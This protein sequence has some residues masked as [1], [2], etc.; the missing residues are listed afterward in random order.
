MHPHRSAASFPPLTETKI[1][2][3]NLFLVVAEFFLC[4]LLF[5]SSRCGQRPGVRTFGQGNS[6]SFSPAQY[7]LI[8]EAQVDEHSLLTECTDDFVA[9][10]QLAKLID[11]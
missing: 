11:A 7:R 6:N 9:A 4:V 10:D 1:L 3:L 2:R 8:G 5:V